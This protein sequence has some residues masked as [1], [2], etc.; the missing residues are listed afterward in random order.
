MFY[1]FRSMTVH[2]G[3]GISIVSFMGALIALMF[4]LTRISNTCFLVG[5]GCGV[6]KPAPEMLARLD[7]GDRHGERGST[8]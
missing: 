5:I 2:I 1:R 7:D 3:L 4:G 6:R 8:Q